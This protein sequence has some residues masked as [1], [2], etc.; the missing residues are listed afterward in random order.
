MRY[1]RTNHRRARTEANV[2]VGRAA[3][4]AFHAHV[5]VAE[6]CRG[7]ERGS[8]VAIRLRC[9]R[10]A[11]GESAQCS[12]VRAVAVVD[13]VDAVRGREVDAAEEDILGMVVIDL[14]AAEMAA[15]ACLAAV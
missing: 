5:A 15:G 2:R 8:A 7:G 4:V 6:E 13:I 10:G 11:L 12:G 9:D 1:G 14:A 3:L